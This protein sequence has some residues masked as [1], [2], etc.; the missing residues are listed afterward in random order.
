MDGD[1][2]NLLEENLKLS[3]QN[4]ELLVKM[5]KAQRWARTMRYIYWALII[6]ISIGGYYLIQPYLGNL[7]N[8]YTGGVSGINEAE[9]ITNTLKSKQLEMKDLLRALNE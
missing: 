3:K 7:L 9:S 8:I 4:N 5:D 1:V 6:F 2:K